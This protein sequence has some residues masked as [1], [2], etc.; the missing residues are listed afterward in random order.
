VGVPGTGTYNVSYL[1]HLGPIG[2]EISTSMTVRVVAGPRDESYAESDNDT[3]WEINPKHRDRMMILMC[4][5][6]GL[7]V[8]EWVIILTRKLR[9]K[10]LAALQEAAAA[11][12]KPVDTVRRPRWPIIVGIFYF[13][14]LLLHAPT[15]WFFLAVINEPN[16]FWIA[17]IAFWLPTLFTVVGGAFLL[18]SVR[19]P[20]TFHVPKARRHIAF[21]IAGSL[22]L[23]LVL[24][25]CIWLTLICALFGDGGGWIV[26][27][28]ALLIFAVWIGWAVFFFRYFKARG[29][30]N[31]VRKACNWLIKG[32]VL[33]ILIGIPT[34]II[35]IRRNDCC[36][37][38]A[39]AWGM[40]IAFSIMFIAFG[41]G[42]VF[43]YMDRLA[44]KR[45]KQA[46]K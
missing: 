27:G 24:A 34:L 28:L 20:A 3:L 11:D 40:I 1:A 29:T 44:R 21:P 9:R 2:G 17:V 22:L 14:A 5:V 39:D 18:L 43:L 6:I 46:G 30:D 10:A 32:S 35:T 16:L 33:E 4:V 23:F 13:I 12:G 25:F 36:A 8:I 38:H 19:V 15:V 42:I 45:A 37:P 31:L 41:P 26:I 7:A